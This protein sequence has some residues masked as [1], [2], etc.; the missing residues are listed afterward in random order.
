MIPPAELV[1]VGDREPAVFRIV[2][3]MWWVITS[4]KDLRL[5]PFSDL[6]YGLMDLRTL[7]RNGGR[8]IGQVPAENPTRQ[9]EVRMEVE[10]GGKFQLHKAVHVM[11]VRDLVLAISIQN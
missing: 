4:P 7:K 1:L 10:S 5:M 11:N 6:K 3:L 8:V 9:G 2:L